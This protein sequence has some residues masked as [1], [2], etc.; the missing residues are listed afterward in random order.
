MHF[1]LADLVTDITQNAA[2]AGCRL[3]EVEVA[4]GG[5]SFRFHVK[6]DGVGM[7]A[8]RLLSAAC[9]FVTDG[10]KHPGRKVGLGLAFLAQTAEQTGGVWELKSEEGKGTLVSG[11]FDTGHWDTPPA[12]DMPFT[13]ASVM[14]FPQPKDIRIV[15]KL[16]GGAAR[17]GAKSGAKSEEKI[18]FKRSDLAGMFGR[19][20][21]GGASR[22]PHE[23]AGLLVSLDR[24]L[25]AWESEVLAKI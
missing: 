15:W 14:M 22:R 11:S 24:R 20:G 23:D 17:R 12:G 18:D 9:P 8:E 25:R 4:Q 7:S 2:E 1:T 16:G 3:L 21:K 13:L 10:V 6:D 5:G 19:G